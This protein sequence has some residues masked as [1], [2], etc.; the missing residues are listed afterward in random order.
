MASSDFTFANDIRSAALLR[1]PRTSRMLLW[2]SCA[3]L[4]TFL[5]W[6]HFAVLDEVKRGSGRVVPS[7]QMQVVQ[8]LE[9][10]IVGDILIREGDIVQQGQSLMRID[11]TKFASEFGEIRERRAAMAARVARLDA[12]ARGRAEITFPDD[13]DKMVPAAVATETSVFKMRGQKVAQD[14]DVLNQQVTRLTGSLKLLEREQTLTRRLYEQK[15]VPEIE[16]LRLDRQATEMKGQLAEAQSKIAN[17]TASFRSQADE[18]LAKS[19]AD[20]AVLDENIK[21]AQDRVRRTDLKAPV[22]GIVNKLNISTIGAVVQPGANLMDI[23]PLDDTLLV[24]GRIRPQDI[25]FIRPDQ[26]AV[27]KIS[28]YDS[29]VYGSL[30]GKVERISADTIVDDKAEKTERQETFYRVMVRTDKNHLGTEQHPLPI[31]PG[32]VTT[33]EVLTGEKSVLDYIV[34]PARLL[35][36]EALRER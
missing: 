14:I 19:R 27:V 20:L 8:S 26:D 2:T 15:V 9:G 29:S 35:R 5:I 34:K 21:S 17:I 32:M 31:I 1:T 7:R 33:V 36:D 6:A 13:L 30:K 23:V 12:E 4:A 3:L 11:D 24:E 25:A 28:A 10:G 22:H 18:D 16:M